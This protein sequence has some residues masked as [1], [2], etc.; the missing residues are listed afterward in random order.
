MGVFN[1]PALESTLA[2]P[3]MTFAGAD[4]YPTLVEKAAA[5]GYP[6]IQNHPFVDGN[7][8][9]GHAAMEVFLVLNGHEIRAAV[10]EQERIILQVAAEERTGK[11]SRS[12]CARISSKGLQAKAIARLPR[13]RAGDSPMLRC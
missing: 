2:Q 12:G 3:R 5:L 13:L 4:L 6:L 8:R 11:H 7:K 10:D 9:T 1:L